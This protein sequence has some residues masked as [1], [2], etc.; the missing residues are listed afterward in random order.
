MAHDRATLAG[1][2]LSIG[3]M[4]FTFSWYGSRRGLHWY[5][6]AILVSALLGFLNFF[7]FLS[8]GYLDIL[9]AFVTC[10]L[11]Q[12]FIMGVYAR[13]TGARK[14]PPPCLK[15]MDSLFHWVHRFY[16][17][18]SRLHRDLSLSDVLDSFKELFFW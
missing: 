2:M 6:E 9:H 12:I 8:Y 16:S 13:N 7:A 15:N 17:L 10:C 14:L 4:Y 18:A 11:F 3:I 1:T 5:K